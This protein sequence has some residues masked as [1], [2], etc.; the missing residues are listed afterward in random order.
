MSP[1][2]PIDYGPNRSLMD[3]KSDTERRLS[4]A[5]GI[6]VPDFPDGFFRKF[7]KMLSLATGCNPTIFVVHVAHVFKMRS[8]PQM[9]RINAGS[10]IA[11]M[12]NAEAIWNWTIRHYPSYLMR[13]PW[14]AVP[15]KISIALPA[16]RTCPKPATAWLGANELSETL[17]WR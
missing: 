16:E 14:R 2:L 8:E 13:F 4:F 7:C 3:P 9:A 15:P 11:R 5:A 12:T 1:S 6:P 17:S 10:H